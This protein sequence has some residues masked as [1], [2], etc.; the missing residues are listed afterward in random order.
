MPGSQ[1]PRHL[2]RHVVAGDGVLQQGH[3]AV[4]HG[5]VEVAAAPGLAGSRQGRQEPD[6][7]EEG[8]AQICRG[9]T[10]PHRRLTGQA[11]D[12]RQPA[13][14][15][16]D[17]VVRRP[18]GVRPALA[19]TGD[20]GVHHAGVAR[21]DPLVVEAEALH[22]AGAEVL[23]EDLALFHQVH[24]QPGPPRRAQIEGDGLL[25][26][27]DA[28]VVGAD[29]GDEGSEV[30]RLVAAARQFHLDHLG[31]EVGQDHRRVGAGQ[32]PGEVEDPHPPQQ[33]PVF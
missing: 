18:V 15:L 11:R 23:D 32:D 30:P 16:H 28:R 14:G 8:G 27:V 9:R 7:G 3:L 10:D 22:G 12:R 4:E 26:A 6:A 17:H 20:R 19:E 29:P 21:R 13:H 24:G 2:L 31:A 1:R 33:R 25:A 5:Q